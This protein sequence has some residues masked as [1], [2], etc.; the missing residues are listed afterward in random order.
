MCKTVTEEIIL[1][2]GFL[3]YTAY[4]LTLDKIILPTFVMHNYYSL[5]IFPAFFCKIS[6][7]VMK[8]MVTARSSVTTLLAATSATVRMDTYWT[9]MTTLAMVST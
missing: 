7:N 2:F 8:R 1:T 4:F 9:L 3:N 6:M 5:F